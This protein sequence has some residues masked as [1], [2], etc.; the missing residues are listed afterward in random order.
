MNNRMGCPVHAKRRH[1]VKIFLP[2]LVPLEMPVH[3]I[4]A[5]VNIVTL[6]KISPT[7]NRC[8]ETTKKYR[9]G[10]SLVCV[11]REEIRCAVKSTLA[12]I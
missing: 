12:P 9:S 2:L 10:C 3:W 1:S 7:P 4:V 8:K 6:A 11:A 5:Y